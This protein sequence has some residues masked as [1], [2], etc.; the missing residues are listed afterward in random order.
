MVR[1]AVR[2][3]MLA[4]VMTA[5]TV[6]VVAGCGGHGGDPAPRP[7]A[8]G[9]QRRLSPVPGMDATPD[10]SPDGKQLVYARLLS[11][12]NRALRRP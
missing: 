1:R 5:I 2:P 11:P 7:A 3:V 12:P 4:A 8:A 10:W 6:T 9:G